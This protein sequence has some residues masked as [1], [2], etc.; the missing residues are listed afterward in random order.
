MTTA[1]G[2]AGVNGVNSRSVAIACNTLMQ[3]AASP[4]GLPVDSIVRAV[5]AQ[6]AGEDGVAFVKRVK[7]ASGQNLGV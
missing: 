2:L 6:T 1:A 4:D 7:H 5:L 3:L